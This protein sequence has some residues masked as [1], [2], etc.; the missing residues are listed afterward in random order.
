MKRMKH[1]ILA[2]LI[3]GTLPAQAAVLTCGVDTMDEADHQDQQTGIV[4]SIKGN[5][6]SHKVALKNDS[7]WDSSK[8]TFE[9]KGVGLGA[10]FASYEGMVL[11]C[12]TAL[13]GNLT[14]RPFFGLNA[15]AAVLIGGPDVGIFANG[16]GGICFLT[17]FQVLGI[18]VG[19]SGAKLTFD[20]V[21]QPQ[22]D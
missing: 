10:R 18:G 5:C 7:G 2:A 1:L 8:L 15:S 20:E 12:P 16:H 14:K 21:P 13:S 3:F 19:I 6:S 17:G 22:N 11:T 9:I 4:E